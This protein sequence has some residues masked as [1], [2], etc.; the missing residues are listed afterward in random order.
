MRSADMYAVRSVCG[1]HCVKIIEH[2]AAVFFACKVGTL[3]FDIDNRRYFNTGKA[4]KY[5]QMGF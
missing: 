5:R 4:L 3:G 1:K 2:P